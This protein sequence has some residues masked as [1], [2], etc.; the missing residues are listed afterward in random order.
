MATQRPTRRRTGIWS[1][2]AMG[3]RSTM[4]PLSGPLFSVRLFGFVTARGVV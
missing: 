4:R 3:A 1:P 2:L